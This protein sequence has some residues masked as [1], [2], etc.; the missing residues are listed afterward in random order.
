LEKGVD[1][2]RL[3]FAFTKKK[4]IIEKSWKVGEQREK[5]SGI[6]KRKM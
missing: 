1:W 5:Q 4:R 2:G 3:A 6:D